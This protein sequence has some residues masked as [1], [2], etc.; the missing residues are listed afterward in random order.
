MLYQS[1]VLLPIQWLSI[2]DD[3]RF[4]KFFWSKFLEIFSKTFLAKLNRLKNH[5]RW[6][7]TV[8]ALRYLLGLQPCAEHVT[9]SN[10]GYVFISK[11]GSN[12]DPP[13]PIFS[14]SFSFQNSL[15][16]V[17]DF[18]EDFLEDFFSW[19]NS[20]VF[21]DFWN[22]ANLNFSLIWNAQRI[23]SGLS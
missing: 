20:I 11:L 23:A 7:L 12:L 6:M 10:F 2:F 8:L 17:E 21:Y 22:R 13:D 14:V 16:F 19:W 18:F 5:K 15:D 4:W 3:F 9:A 1:N